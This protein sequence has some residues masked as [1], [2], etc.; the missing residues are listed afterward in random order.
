MSRKNI[1]QTV[2][3]IICGKDTFTKKT[4]RSLRVWVI[5]PILTVKD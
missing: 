1:T 2:D 4:P 3:K 5:E